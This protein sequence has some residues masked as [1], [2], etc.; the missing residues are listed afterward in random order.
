[1]IAHKQC[2]ACGQ[3]KP[4]KEFQ[5]DANA[6]DGLCY[7]CREC[8][9]AYFR[10]H[11]PEFTKRRRKHYRQ[12]AEKI[13][14]KKRAY[15]R[16]H[17][18]KAKAHD[19]AHRARDRGDLVPQRCEDCGAAPESSVMHHEDYNHP[20]RITWLCPLCHWRRHHR[21]DEDTRQTVRI[22]SE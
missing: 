4:H 17:P 20:L 15:Y 21:V 11:R 9:T 10:G 18:D 7:Q 2:T 13:K 16:A 22:I 14:A 8:R 12:N 6:P 19:R 3:V 5:R 1:M